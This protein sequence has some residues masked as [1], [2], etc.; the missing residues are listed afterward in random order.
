ML[1]RMKYFT[2]LRSV[3]LFIILSISFYYLLLNFQN[4]LACSDAA[5]FLDPLT[6]CGLMHHERSELFRL[7]EQLTATDSAGTLAPDQLLSTSEQ[8]EFS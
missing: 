3:S 5:R 2:K 8:T 6:S 7:V 1:F 4:L